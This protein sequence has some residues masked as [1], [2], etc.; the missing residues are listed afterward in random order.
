MSIK[1][2]KK[3]KTERVYDNF[4]KI[5]RTTFK[6]QDGKLKDFDIVTTDHSVVSVV[7]FTKDKK[8][9]L[10]KQY[11]PGPEKIFYEFPLGYIE[12]GETSIQAAKREFLEETGYV[13]HFKKI[14]VK[15]NNG[16]SRVK[17]HCYLASDCQKTESKLKL[18]EA[19][20]IEV[21][22]VS[23]KELRKMLKNGKIRNFGEGYLALDY[24]NLL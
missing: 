13:G 18:D 6:L 21:H 4:K 19:E 7:G 24:L 16:Y 9:I 8:A 5:D 22:L 17:V 3:I 14:G 12:E 1:N 23:L 11:R 20:F 10:T 15:Y 2:W